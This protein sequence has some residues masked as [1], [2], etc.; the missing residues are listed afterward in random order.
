MNIALFANLKKHETLLV[1]R[2]ICTFLK[3]KG[4]NVVAPE[5][6]A[7]TLNIEPFHK[8][9]DFILAMGG[10]G[11]ILRVVHHFP[12]CKA[13]IVGINM[14]RLG[15][16]SEII[17]PEINSS[18]EA[19]LQGDFRIE[20]R[21]MME[22]FFREQHRFAVNDFVIHRGKNPS[23]IDLSISVDGKY[24][25]TFS[26]DGMIFSTP[27]G[28]T[29]YSLASGGPILSPE[30]NALVIT[31]ICPHT[32]SNRPL[33][34]MPQEKIEVS[35]LSKKEPAEITYDGFSF[36]E[37]AQDEIFT[38]RKSLKYFRIVILTK[39]DYFSTLRTKLGWSGQA[40]LYNYM[41]TPP[42]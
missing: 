11:T 38:I 21:I 26:A 36:S 27:N 25:N 37:I 5:E 13:P 28:S 35:Y 30:L 16:M 3:Q 31:P 39:N 24:L 14:G 19:L 9:V 6:M 8:D 1:A 23:L 18:L 22:G 33:V 2:Q 20:E 4:V 34:L 15:F 7:L 10:D 41:E 17:L 12:D 40:R 32:I 29:A 42:L